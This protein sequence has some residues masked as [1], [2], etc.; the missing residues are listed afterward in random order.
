MNVSVNP[1]GGANSPHAVK[2]D[3]PSTGD[4]PIVLP[5][6]PDFLRADFHQS[7][8]D[9]L[10]DVPDG[11]Q[12]VAV[13][14]FLSD[15][16]VDL[17]LA[18]GGTLSA[19]MVRTLAGPDV[20]GLYAQAN[21]AGVAGLGEPIGS[22]T[23]IEGSAFVTHPDGVRLKLAFGDSIF[24]GDVVASGADSNVGI[25]FVDDTMFSLSENGRMTIDEM[26][27]DPGIQDGAFAATV[28]T[29]VFSFVSG[30]IAKTSPDAMGLNT[31]SGTIGIRGST[32]VVKVGDDGSIQVAL[33]R[34]VNGNLGE[35]VF[36]NDG[37]AM[38]LN[39][40]NAS[41]VIAG[42][43]VAPTA[44]R[45]LTA[46][47]VQQEYGETL[48]TLTRTIASKAEKDA[49]QDQV[50]AAAAEAKSAAANQDVDAAKQDADA[51]DADAAQA[52]A[53]AETAKADAQ[54]A[55][56]E[57][58]ALALEA[59]T[60]A[61]EEAKAAAEEAQIK[62][63][64]AAQA[65][66]EAQ[67]EAAT[68][69]A[70]AAETEIKVQTAEAEAQAA[71]DQAQA[72][73]DQA[74]QSAQFSTLAT[75]AAET[76]AESF[77]AVAPVAPT[78]QTEPQETAP[79]DEPAPTQNED[80][81]AADATSDDPPQD[82]VPTDPELVD[83]AFAELADSATT[84]ETV[85]DPLVEPVIGTETF[86]ATDPV[87]TAALSMIGEEIAVVTEP[88]PT[89][90]PPPPTTTIVTADPVVNPTITTTVINNNDPVLTAASISGL[91]DNE[92]SGQV[93]GT[94][95]N[96][97]T[98]TFSLS[99]GPSNGSIS[100]NADGTFI[101]APS[102]D[103]AGTDSFIIA[104]SDGNGGIG[105]S[106][107]SVDVTAVN[108]APV[109]GT[110][111]GLTVNLGSAITL[112][113]AMLN[114]TDVDNTASALTYSLQTT[115]VN[116]SLFLGQANLQSGAS[117]TQ[118]DLDSGLL[119]YTHGG[120]SVAAD[121]IQFTVSDGV[122]GSLGLTDFIFSIS[123]LATWTN[124]GGDGAWATT[125]NWNTVAVPTSTTD[126][127][128]SS[129]GLVLTTTTTSNSVN[130]T[131]GV[132]VM[133]NG[134]SNLSALTENAGV[135]NISG[136]SSNILTT[137]SF[138]TNSG[139]INILGSASFTS[140]LIV[141]S[142][143]LTNTGTIT[144]GGANVYIDANLTSS[145]ILNFSGPTHLSKIG[146][147]YTSSGSLTVAS[148]QTLY[149]DGDS[150]TLTIQSG[151]TFTNGGTVSVASGST[152]TI[153]DA[154]TNASTLTSAGAIVLSG[155]V[156]NTGTLTTTGGSLN[157]TTVVNSGTFSVAGTTSTTTVT[158]SGTFNL[159][160]G[161]MSGV[162]T[163][164]GVFNLG[165][166]TNASLSISN[167][168]GATMNATGT[169]TLSALT[170]NSGTLNYFA[171]GG[172]SI[173][174]GAFT[175]NFGTINMAGS[176]SYTAALIMA[177]GTLT[178]TGTI[179]TTTAYSRIT[180]DLT[181]DGTLT[182]NGYTYFDKVG[183][184]YVNTS[185]GSLSV[186]S[187]QILYVQ[188]SGTTLTIAA[189][190]TYS[191]LG[192][193]RIETGATATIV[194]AQTNSGTL[195][196]DSGTLNLNGAL[197]NTGTVTVVGF[198]ASL[199]TTTVAN[200]GTMTLEGGSTSGVITNTGTLSFSGTT[201]SSLSISNASGA[202]LNVSKIN[203]GGTVTVAS[204]T[205]NAGDLVYATGRGN[206]FT[207]GTFATSSG[208]ILM[209][210]S[211]ASTYLNVTSGTFTNSG[212]ITTEVAQRA[213][214][215]ANLT[216]TGTLNFNTDT[217][218]A[219]AGGTYSNAGTLN[220]ATGKTLFLE[221]SGTTLTL[222]TGTTFNNSGT[223]SVGSGSTLT[224]QI[225]YSGAAALTLAGGTAI[226]N[227]AY[228][229][230]SGGTVTTSSGSTLT[231]NGGLT[232]VG[233]LTIAA[234]TVSGTITNTGTLTLS[235]TSTMT[236]LSL[237]NQGTLNMAGTVTIGTIS[238]NTGI[239]DFSGVNGQTLTVTNFT[240]NAG[241][242]NIA[243]AASW[244]SKLILTNGMTNTGTIT[245]SAVTSA[246]H[247]IEGNLTNSGTLTLNGD[248]TFGLTGTTLTNSG[249]ITLA[250][251]KTL[252]LQN[253]ATLTN[254]SAGTIVASGTID[255]T[256]GTFT[257]SGT[258]E[259]GG[260]ATVGTMTI[261]GDVVNT[262]TSLLRFDVTSSAN[263]VINISGNTTLA[264]T[265]DVNF[266]GGAPVSGTTYTVA[267]FASSTLGVIKG[268]SHNLGSDW[269]ISTTLS[270]TDITL[271]ADQGTVLTGTAGVDNFNLSGGLNIFV[272]GGAADN[273]TGRTGTDVFRYVAVTDSVTGGGDTISNF[274][275]VGTD[276]INLQG[277]MTGH[278][279]G[280]II[281]LGVGGFSNTG[282]TQIGF[283]DTTKLLQIDTNGD[284]TA[285]M[286]I[287][288]TGVAIATLDATDFTFV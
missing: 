47:E 237:D 172:T 216:N 103:Y 286:D 161:S 149:V 100:V 134:T 249:T 252:L 3:T 93:T 150:S 243:A 133:V 171:T 260:V 94:D 111:V 208:T 59:E 277:L 178:N 203:T 123:D 153:V 223:L 227:A 175:T 42:A 164:T 284:G 48:N 132:S 262:A 206:T 193:L 63:D 18:A 105:Y 214:I 12:F 87:I 182:F 112:T 30:Q 213:Y 256:A 121:K 174:I 244:T 97:D 20:S 147:T 230:A 140:R 245:T 101:Y 7:G 99:T 169:S 265:I 254:D 110:N 73:Q 77:A 269:I 64:I 127:T 10:I 183:G 108:D 238:S 109:I 17:T 8:F 104:G 177:S 186:A 158:N 187:G 66:A 81:P 179:T 185:S 57:A 152:L 54:V 204:V 255:A 217:Y 118:A 78:P 136:G 4:G 65:E 72:A 198:G 21:D 131:S 264:G 70:Q 270:G 16:P 139:V 49:T 159:N 36:T 168:S 91:E 267:S 130:I 176:G 11:G 115:T 35:L 222:Q 96:S 53:D 180:T 34:D 52:K 26:V 241:T 190:S 261:T 138:T 170:D 188:G 90:P 234:S 98:I 278:W 202:T 273:L 141:S 197:T 239:I 2:L 1:G 219:K 6:G 61:T 163:N 247:A 231:I 162:V 69:Q 56:D 126:V 43:G 144:T 246:N 74:S 263:D 156:T 38:V 232:N 196:V 200:L 51:A 211:A 167:A 250:T 229:I 55:Q 113:T 276:I 207:A 285:D 271:T 212:T 218:F 199:S 14:Y 15:S 201:N 157:T 44:V 226:L 189:G 28:L 280:A 86:P 95:A 58:D 210:G 151:S 31:P 40:E 145:G 107:V 282:T 24:Q 5:A 25:V 142:G 205:D 124:T 155:G 85:V 71:Q 23:E 41:T 233:T 215:N 46:Q 283:N 181:N 89:L 13:D 146:G 137:S 128:I 114:I 116:G 45:I 272:G 279:N 266:I 79:T 33:L 135:L 242:I 195:Y 102:A 83:P 82:P 173:T 9:L 240:T 194:D 209:T 275:A 288:L 119:A 160:S 251:G 117:F 122:G 281:D 224:L 221:G 192:T 220:I 248:L 166:S 228:T 80:G 258:L 22:V 27:F 68:A 236:G 235:G 120:G 76:Q 19:G 154:Y 60:A 184:T 253:S 191:N 165:A 259:A 67:I 225:A 106:T 274:E 257:N 129:N 29:G 88:L 287:T 148:G 62:A 268:V 37:G 125:T 92:M 50:K 39:Q 75:T 32:G 84:A 143:T